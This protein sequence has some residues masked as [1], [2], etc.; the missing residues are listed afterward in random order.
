[1]RHAT[2]YLLFRHAL[3][4]LIMLIRVD[5]RARCYAAD[6]AIRYAMRAC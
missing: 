3:L 4:M 6:A 5:A 2:H 1:M